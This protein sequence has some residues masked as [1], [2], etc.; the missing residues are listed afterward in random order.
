MANSVTGSLLRDTPSQQTHA[1]SHSHPFL[2]SL[3]WSLFCVSHDLCS[4]LDCL[5]GFRCAIGCHSFHR[6]FG[7]TFLPT[8]GSRQASSSGNM[9]SIS[10]RKTHNFFGLSLS[11][12]NLARQ[13]RWLVSCP[14]RVNLHAVVVQ[15]R[16][17]A[18]RL[19]YNCQDTSI[20]T[21][22]RPPCTCDL[23]SAVIACVSVFFCF[24]H[25]TRTQFLHASAF[26]DHRILSF[27]FEQI[28]H[29]DRRQLQLFQRQALHDCTA[30]YVCAR[31]RH[32]FMCRR[33]ET[34][35]YGLCKAADV[36]RS[37]PGPGRR[38]HEAV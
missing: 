22:Q 11:L 2:R 34:S 17:A 28:H 20:F 4:V 15:Q 16:R 8:S 30:S 31:S 5:N 6:I 37:G 14:L 9:A 32:V 26:T 38:A 13:I 1:Q 27:F 3:P 25:S 29:K 21:L 33:S 23:Q 12:F 36:Q 18:T 7:S 10:S 24:R 35:T 19:L